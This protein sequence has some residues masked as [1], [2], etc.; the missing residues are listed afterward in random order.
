MRVIRLKRVLKWRFLLFAGLAGL[1]AS[2][3][4]TDESQ[5]SSSL[6]KVDGVEL[7]YV[8]LG[9]G[10]PLVFI[11]GA[12]DDYRMWETEMEPFGR[13][14]RAIAYS[15]RYNFPNHNSVQVTDY[16]AIVDAEDVAGL[17]QSLKLGRVHLVAH[18]YGGYAALFLVTRHPELVRSLVLAE[19]AVLNWAADRPAGQPLF[20]RF[21]KMWQPVREA[22]QSGRDT[23]ALEMTLDYFE[24]KGAFQRLPSAAQQVLRDNLEEWRALTRSPNIFP[25]LPREQVARVQVPT[26]LLTGARTLPIHQFIDAELQSLLPH[27]S[28][29]TIPQAGHEM[30]ADNA[31]ACRDATLKF[32]R[33]IDSRAPFLFPKADDSRRVS[34]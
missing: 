13:Y 21:M 17:I 16:S 8:V 6:I 9:S 12:L 32:L 20:E 28:S 25:P 15:R 18:S 10:S 5:S 3:G 19:P 14:Y 2:Q 24:G 30:W 11:H 31:E 22:L 29:V 4:A 23:Q 34:K 26:L 33:G 1:T 7:H 27:A